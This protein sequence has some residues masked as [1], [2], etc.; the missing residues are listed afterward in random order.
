MAG[1]EVADVCAARHL[2]ARLAIQLPG[3]LSRR[4]SH[5]ARRADPRDG[6]CW[7]SD[8]LVHQGTLSL[9]RH[10]EPVR[11]HRLRVQSARR[12]LLWDGFRRRRPGTRHRNLRG[13]VVCVYWALDCAHSR[14]WTRRGS[15]GPGALSDADL[16]H[17][18]SCR[19]RVHPGSQ[20][21]RGLRPHLA[22]SSPLGLESQRGR[23]DGH[24]LDQPHRRGAY[25]RPVHP[26][27]PD[28]PGA[29]SIG[30]DG[31]RGARVS[32]GLRCWRC[33]PGTV[34]DG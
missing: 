31:G 27:G 7:H 16:L 28:P 33:S 29:L 10:S 25:T 3:R 14:S 9:H 17:H 24:L 20:S 1:G 19:A 11:R 30:S 32:R 21:Q 5:L 26:V 34:G 18:F 2:V 15:Y 8:A 23:T 12:T 22:R 13:A 4:L 6:D